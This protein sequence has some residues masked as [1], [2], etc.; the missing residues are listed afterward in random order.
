MIILRIFRFC[1]YLYMVFGSL[2]LELGRCTDGWDGTSWEAFLGLDRAGPVIW[3]YGWD[4][5]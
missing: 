4:I 3:G 5:S 2:I 1:V